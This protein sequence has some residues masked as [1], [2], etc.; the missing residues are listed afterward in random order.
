MLLFYF[1][2]EDFIWLFWRR[3][4][5]RRQRRYNILRYYF[6]CFWSTVNNLIL[7]FSM[8]F[9]SS[10]RDLKFL[11]L[12]FEIF[13]ISWDNLRYKLLKLFLSLFSGLSLDLKYIILYNNNNKNIIFHQLDL[14]ISHEW[15]KM[16]VYIILKIISLIMADIADICKTWYIVN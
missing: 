11:K 5:S 15:K 14:E 2:Q 7:R 12:F 6:K 1:S 13:E 3:G 9:F 4:M 8:I 10:R 16:E